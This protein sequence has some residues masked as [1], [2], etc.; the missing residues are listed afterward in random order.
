[1]S[2]NHSLNNLSK[3][4]F[5][6]ICNHIKKLKGKLVL[7]GVG[8]SGHI[9]AKIS[10]TLSSTGTPSFFINPSEAS[11]G[12]LGAISK[13]DGILIISNSGETDEIVLIL[14]GLM[15][16]TK[17]ILSITGN[18][19]SSIAKNSLV[20]LEAKVDK[21]ACPNNLAPTT[22]TSFMLMLG[23]AISIALLKN[24]RFSPKEFAENH[25]GGK[26]GKRFLLAKDLMIDIK[27]IPI[28]KEN[29][30]I[31]EAIKV[32]TQFGLGFCLVKNSKQ[33]IN[34]IFTDGDLRRTLNKKIDIRN[35][36]ISKVMTKSFKSIEHNKNAYLAREIMSKN[37]IYSLV[38]KK[39]KKVIGVI[40]MHEL[41]ES[42]VF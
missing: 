30:S 42:R 40:R 3:K 15:K 25:P 17:N 31:L 18:E 39:Q 20:H 36:S 24:N 7:M 13:N 10:S 22:S 2:I 33:S 37:K 9:A 26:L 34:A 27:E 21:E 6:L 4:D 14:S 29:T 16:K 41:N 12:D 5:N 1:S 11:H 32:I 19:E 38:V 35:L 8:K 23:D 28:V